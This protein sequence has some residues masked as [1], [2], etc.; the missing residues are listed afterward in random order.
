MGFSPTGK[1]REG[2]KKGKSEGGY[3]NLDSQLLDAL[4]DAF[5]LPD[6]CRVVLFQWNQDLH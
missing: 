3:H 5:A 2:G 4:D 1:W 6:V